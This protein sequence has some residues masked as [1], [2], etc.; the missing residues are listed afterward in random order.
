MLW[1]PCVVP[2]YP[3]VV[4][5]GRYPFL[6]RLTFVAVLFA[7][8]IDGSSWRN[9][10]SVKEY[11]DT[12]GLA[13]DVGPSASVCPGGAGS[14]GGQPRMRRGS[15]MMSPSRPRPTWDPGHLL[16]SPHLVEL[17]ASLF[18]AGLYMYNVYTGSEDVPLVVSNV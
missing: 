9:Q 14:G 6:T 2:A 7:G 3:I 17:D 16:V 8:V 10:W 4:Q 5:V 13:V 18:G 12:P 1:L 15:I 11:I